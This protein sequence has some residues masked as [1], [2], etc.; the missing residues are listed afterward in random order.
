MSHQATF[1]LPGTRSGAVWREIALSARALP[2]WM[3][4]PAFTALGHHLVRSTPSLSGKEAWNSGWRSSRT[5]ESDATGVYYDEEGRPM[6][7]STQVHDPAFNARVVAETRVPRSRT[8]MIHTPSGT[9][10][11][12]G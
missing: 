7:D 9:D 10:S 1:A 3:P 5:D 6:R 4:M 12:A 8:D 11:A 2:D